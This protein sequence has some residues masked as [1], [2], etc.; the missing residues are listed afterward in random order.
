L[1]LKLVGTSTSRSRLES[2]KRLI[3]VSSRNFNVS[4]RSRLGW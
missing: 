3:S 4:S 1:Q 2:Y